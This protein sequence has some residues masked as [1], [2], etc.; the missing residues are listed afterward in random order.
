MRPE[1]AACPPRRAARWRCGWHRPSCLRRID[2]LA[3]EQR[4]VRIVSAVL[5]HRVRH[6][7]AVGD[8]Q[9]VVVG[10]MARRDM[11]EARAGI[12]RHEVA[13][14]QAHVELEAA[15]R[16]GGDQ[17]L[18][19]VGRNLG[20]DLR[21]EL[22]LRGNRI[23]Q[24]AREHQS[25]AHLRL[26]ALSDGSDF[27]QRVGDVAAVGQR[28]VAR[29]GPRCRRPDHDGGAVELAAPR[30]HDR[31]AHMDR[32]RRVI[33]IFDLGFGQRGLLDH[34]PQHRLRALVEAAV[35]QE[36]AQF[37]HD[38]RLGLVLHRRVVIVPVTVDAEAL[39][40]LALDRDPVIG[41]GPALAPELDDRD[42]VLVLLLGAVLLLDL[43]LDRQ[44]VAVPARDIVAVLAQHLLGAA[45][46]VLQDLVERVADMQVAV[47]V[48]RAVVQHEL[49][50]ALALLAKPVPQLH[51]GPA[52]QELGLLLGQARTH[53]EIGLRQENA[54]FIISCHRKLGAGGS[55]F[56]PPAGWPLAG[57]TTRPRSADR[58]GNSLLESPGEH[59]ARNLGM[60]VGGQG[61][62]D[63]QFRRLPPPAPVG[64]RQAGVDS[65]LVR[66]RA[67]ILR[68]RMTSIRT[69]GQG[70]ERALTDRLPLVTTNDTQR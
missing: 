54:G 67:A 61:A 25:L 21:R 38:D 33:V 40:L 13:R 23:D 22:R 53:G 43:P 46:Q 19:V 44:A 27:D 18:E 52:L 68:S 58:A 63:R 9:L 29:H 2:A 36:L 69:T 8:A 64:Y 4:H 66:R 35:E 45:D 30:P 62:P 42:L 16:M 60:G 5:G 48:G 47:G 26:A 41:E 11:H 49:R 32:V 70:I 3:G 34:R 28:P 20:H 59:R 51:V 65:N 10:A 39:E 50:A 7:D 31:E 17:P 14:Q 55:K 15:E 1:A 57:M 6:L 56:Q 12:G 24:V 37:P